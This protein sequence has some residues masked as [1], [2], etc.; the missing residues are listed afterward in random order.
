MS[1]IV[2]FDVDGTVIRSDG[3]P[4]P[5]AGIAIRTLMALGYDIHFWSARGEHYARSVADRI[6]L[7]LPF[8]TTHTKPPM[9]MTEFEALRIIGAR[10]ALQIDNERDQRIADW[11]FMVWR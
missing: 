6:G 9:P 10:P 1:G 5:G 11:P 2:L 4:R 8:I 3:S 7:G